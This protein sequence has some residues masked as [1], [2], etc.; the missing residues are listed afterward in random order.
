MS[1]IADD[2]DISDSSMSVPDSLDLKLLSKGMNIGHLN[3]QGIQNKIE[4]LKIIFSSS[5][6]L[7]HVLG[8]RETKLKDFHSD[9]VIMI[10][11]YTMFRKDRIQNERRMEAGDGLIA[12]VKNTVRCVRR[13]DLEQDDIECMFLEIFPPNSRSFLLGNI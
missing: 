10:D 2:I 7:I 9:N 12:D 6:N 3:I 5:Q 8:L 4:Q 11:N 1:S 13:N